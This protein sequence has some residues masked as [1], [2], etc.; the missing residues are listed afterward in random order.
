MRTLLVNLWVFVLLVVALVLLPPLAFD[1]YQLASRAWG[2][3]AN[4]PRATLPNYRG[5]DWAVRHFREFASISTSYQ[6]YIGWRREPFEGQTI[7]VDAEGYRVHPGAPRREQADVWVFGGST[8]WGPGASDEHTIPARLQAQSGR[9]VFNFGESAYTAHQSYNLLVKSYLQGGQPRHVV[10]YDGANEVVI[11]CRAEL[12]FY[13]AS[14]EATIRARMHGNSM[15]AQL[16]APTLE[17]LGRGLRLA[18]PSGRQ[19]KGYDCSSNEAKRKQIAAALVM[20]WRLARQLVESRGGRFV[21]VLQPISFTGTPRLDHLPGLQDAKALR[22]QY[23]AV[24]PE[25]RRQ[26]EQAGIPYADLTRA[27]DGDE[28]VY[29]DFAHVSPRGNELIAQGIAKLLN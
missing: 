29:I 16:L 6:D 25:I 26:L 13:S 27:F 17:L 2:G 21:A 8:I 3:G 7:H 24:Y 19:D 10:F 23:D 15:S 18:S 14:H 22:E 5:V 28:Y 9:P 11:K 4:D 1:G 12:N 20:D